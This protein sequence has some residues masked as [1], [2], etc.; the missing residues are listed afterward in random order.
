MLPATR[1]NG[2]TCSA[3]SR[4]P[5]RI[6]NLIFQSERK[7]ARSVPNWRPAYAA[8]LSSTWFTNASIGF[9]KVMISGAPRKKNR[10]SPIIP[11]ES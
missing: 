10:I 3:S 6:T 7:K 11:I 1:L 2:R 9:T 5:N 4:N 8:K